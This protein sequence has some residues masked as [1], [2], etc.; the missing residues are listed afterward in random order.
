MAGTAHR[1]LVH[2]KLRGKSPGDTVGLPCPRCCGVEQ[3]ARQVQGRACT[4]PPR[5]TKAWTQA[6]TPGRSQLRRNTST[7]GWATPVEW[8]MIPLGTM[9]RPAR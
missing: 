7:S 1:V 2:T 9:V 6:S 4:T 5:W 8:T 3:Q